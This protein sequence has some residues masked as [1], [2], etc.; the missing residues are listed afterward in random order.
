[1]NNELAI[2]IIGGLLSSLFLTLV[3]VQVVFSIF[4]RMEEKFSKKEDKNY[5]ELIE[6]EYEHINPKHESE[7]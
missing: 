2:V 3:I 1:M 5:E 7:F 4:V 6:A